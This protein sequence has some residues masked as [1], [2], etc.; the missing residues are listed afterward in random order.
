MEIY[1]IKLKLQDK[2]NTFL[3]I[4]LIVIRKMC[5]GPIICCRPSTTKQKYF[6]FV[7]F[8]LFG[9]LGGGF[10]FK[11]LISI[12]I[13]FLSVFSKRSLKPFFST[14][15]IYFRNIIIIAITFQVF[16]K[17]HE[18]ETLILHLLKPI[19]YIARPSINPITVK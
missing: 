2:I 3:N 7:L 9:C 10:Y 4:R 17:S 5:L 1:V 8:V 11:F 13:T 18:T 14:S 12:I 19:S 16:L 6:R 15:K